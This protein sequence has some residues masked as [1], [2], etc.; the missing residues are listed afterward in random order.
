MRP[1]FYSNVIRD[2]TIL[3][4]NKP[5]IENVRAP[6][7]YI[8]YQWVHLA[9]SRINGFSEGSGRLDL[10]VRFGRMASLPA[11]RTQA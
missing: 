8:F 5:T 10:P 6:L 2:H 3:G 11:A 4:N 1:V 7:W 9:S